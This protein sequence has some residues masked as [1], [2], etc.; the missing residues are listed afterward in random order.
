M[1]AI[2]AVLPPLSDIG[3]ERLVRAMAKAGQAAADDFG[4][5]V[6]KRDALLAYA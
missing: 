2:A 6:E 3:A 1:E 4:A 5:L